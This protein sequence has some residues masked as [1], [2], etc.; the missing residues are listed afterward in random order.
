MLAG[1]RRLIRA[2]KI[3]ARDG[4]IPKPLRVLAAI[5]LLP[6][7]GPFDELVLVVVG[8]LLWVFYRRPLLEAWSQ[9]SK[10]ARALD[11]PHVPQSFR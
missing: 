8:S 3:L 6:V 7:P 10:P 9:A 5:G 4:R 2:V 1:A 11:R